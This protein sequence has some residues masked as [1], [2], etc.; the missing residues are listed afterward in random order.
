MGLFNF[1]K[2]KEPIYNQKSIDKKALEGTASN[3]GNSSFTGKVQKSGGENTD[4]QL[5]Y[6]V[7]Y[8]VMRMEALNKEEVGISEY[9]E[10]M[11]QAYRDMGQVNKDIHQLNDE[12]SGLGRYAQNIT[13][14]MDRSDAV[15]GKTHHRVQALTD[16][17]GEIDQQ[18]VEITLVF[19][20]L[21]ENFSKIK[22]LSDGITGIASRTNLLALNASIEAARAGEAGRG[23]SVVAEN[24]RELSGATTEL[25]G[26]INDSINALY[27]S[28]DAVNQAIDS[29]KGK[30]AEN[31]EFVNDVQQSFQ[32][33]ADCTREVRDFSGR[34]VKG[35][36]TTSASVN[37]AASG[38]NSLA[39]VVTSF[40]ER[41]GELKRLMSKKNL[42]SCSMV[43]FLQMMEN[44]LK[45]RMHR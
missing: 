20:T 29:T 16:K 12:F 8:L 19:Q 39:G 45:D 41:I 17:M 22:K 42:I 30:T 4:E 13:E 25:V 10:Q 1:G 26:G 3:P 14:I 9:I 11:T 33:V 21:E 37:E 15:V 43:D 27:K 40:K 2:S 28:I 24:I 18:L 35:I 31:A 32:E 5:L 38:A 23:F 6:G 7:N 34:I 36:E 44:M